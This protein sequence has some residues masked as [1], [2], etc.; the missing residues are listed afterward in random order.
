MTFVDTEHFDA[1]YTYRIVRPTAQ[2]FKVQIE[3][4]DETLPGDIQTQIKNAVVQDFL[5]ELKNPRVTLASTVYASRFYQCVQSV[6]DTPIKTITIGLGDGGLSTSVEVP[7]NVSPT[8]IADN[9][10]ILFDGD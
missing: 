1:V 3:F 2:D 4:Y 7:A 9:V 5:G 10:T 6:T 8:L